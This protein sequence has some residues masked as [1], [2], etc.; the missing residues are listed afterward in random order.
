MKLPRAKYGDSVIIRVNN[1]LHEIIINECKG[2]YD[3]EGELHW[4]YYP[5]G[6]SGSLDMLFDVDILMN[7]TTQTVFGE[8]TEFTTIN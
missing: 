5:S 7:L 6:K 1:E 3:D 4:G 8:E 2:F